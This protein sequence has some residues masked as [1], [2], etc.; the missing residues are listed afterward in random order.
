MKKETK[1]FR[2]ANEGRRGKYQK[3]RKYFWKEEDKKQDF[4]KNK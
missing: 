2:K 1:Y 3:I 4:K